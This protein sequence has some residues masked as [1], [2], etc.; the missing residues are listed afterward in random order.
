MRNNA[1]LPALLI[2]ALA[3][4]A[5]P[6]GGPDPGQSTLGPKLVARLWKAQHELAYRGTQVYSFDFGE[7][8]GTQREAV[9][10]R[11]VGP[12]KVDFSLELVEFLH[13][14]HTQAGAVPPEK[15]GQELF[16]RWAG[17]QFRYRG[18][19]IQNPDLALMNYAFLPW[20]PSS[21]AGRECDKWFVIPRVL[22]RRAWILWVDR[23]TGLVLRH[24][25]YSPQGMLIGSLEFDARGLQIGPATDFQGVDRWWHSNLGEVRRFNNLP[26][27][28]A[29]FGE[30]ALV[31]SY[32]PAGYM[33]LEARTTIDA[34][35]DDFL[36]LVYS[37]GLDSLFLI[38][39]S[40]PLG[41]GLPSP[42]PA[43][44]MVLHRF[45][46]GTLVQ[47]WTT[48]EGRMVMLMGRL[49]EDQIPLTFESIF[50]RK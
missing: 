42:E 7:G 39:G 33:L 48:V 30:P 13:R 36:V 14:G 8:V 47:L 28:E 24:Q 2:T 38:N 1:F 23:E 12:G 45:M 43:E 26:A 50:P 49:A 22:D 16:S 44:E 35:G 19:R 10:V 21:A 3:G 46:L 6:Q 41:S 40:T 15:M 25:E 31:P 17:S 20:G 27:A 5:A 29:A 4:A 11:P 32:L 34:A 18:F 37:D 9:A